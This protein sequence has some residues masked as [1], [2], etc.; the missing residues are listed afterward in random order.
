MVNLLARRARHDCMMCFVPIKAT[1]QQRH[2]APAS[3]RARARLP[4]YAWAPSF[5]PRS[6]PGA[7]RQAYPAHRGQQPDRPAARSPPRFR[8]KPQRTRRV[9]CGLGHRCSHDPPLSAVRARAGVT[10]RTCWPRPRAL[11]CAAAVR[12]RRARRPQLLAFVAGGI[13]R[14]AHCAAGTAKRD[15]GGTDCSAR[16]P[17]PPVSE[18]FCRRTRVA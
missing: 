4:C 5:R 11:S 6:D 1:P 9:E 18:R 15:T 10:A 8:A 12:L 7:R 13:S 2:I 16:R 3:A 17:Q 14:H